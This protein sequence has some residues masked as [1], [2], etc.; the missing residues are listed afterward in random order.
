V[1]YRG[2]FAPSP[3]G[4]LH[5]GSL[6]AAVASY[7]DARH[8]G[9]AWLV[10]IEDLDPPREMPGAA[11]SIIETLDAF[12]FEWNESILR[13]STRTAAYRDALDDLLRRNMAFPCSCSRTELQA[14]QD[15]DRPPSDELHYPGWCRNGVRA[16]ERPVAI[17]FRVDPATI[18]FD[19]LIQGPQAC[20]VSAD[21]G[22]FVIRRR[23]G[24]FAYQLAVVVDD[25]AQGITRVV[26]GTDLLGSTARQILLQRALGF[27]TPEYAHMPV[28]TDANGVKL[29][30][31]TGAAQIDPRRPS[32]ELWRA[33]RFLQQAPPPELR[34][35]PTATLWTWAV[36]NWRAQAL[37]G[38]RAKA[39]RN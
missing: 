21:V 25:A 27:A 26:R 28:V 31:S 20:D 9:G 11:D 36:E 14:A 29:S 34:L 7:L 38:A 30:K 33:L 16:P 35:S 3:T 8:A 15:P 17:R 2:R 39:E 6:V 12:G 22:D 4:P 1:S 32:H 37:K 18:A 5:F 19:D 10:R 13:Q 23:D 24:L